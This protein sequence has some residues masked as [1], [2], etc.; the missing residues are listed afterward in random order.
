MVN[1]WSA[2]ARALSS[3]HQRSA[4][5]AHASSMTLIRPPKRAWD[6]RIVLAM[7]PMVARETKQVLRS[8]V[9]EMPATVVQKRESVQQQAPA[10]RPIPFPTLRPA[11]VRFVPVKAVAHLTREVRV[12]RAVPIAAGTRVSGGVLR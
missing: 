7:H 5:R 2:W 10:S 9:R 3:K 8:T 11:P 12:E 4:E 6:F 1:R